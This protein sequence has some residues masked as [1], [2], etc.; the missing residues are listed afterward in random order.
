MTSP[1]LNLRYVRV[2]LARTMRD[3]STIM[4]IFLMPPLLFLVFGSSQQ[5]VQVMHA[6]LRFYVLGGMAA[7][8]ATTG[9]VSIVG[10]AANEAM[11]GWG[12]QIALT[13]APA[14]GMVTNKVAL[15]LIVCS[16][17]IVVT[18][19]VGLATGAHAEIGVWWGTFLGC[20]VGSLMFAVYGLAVGLNFRA[21]SAV[22]AASAGMVFFSFLGNV[23]MPLSGVMLTIAHFTPM[24]GVMALV[25]WPQLRGNVVS[26]DGVQGSDSMWQL[27]LSVVVWLAIFTAF[28]LRGVRVAR[29]RR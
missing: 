15:T 17:S 18:L 11:Q 19:L 25:R 13:K 23:F 3:V 6:N 2:D 21:E 20:L 7:Y 10:Q 1:A 24:Y 22:G 26:T 12:C 28:A 5:M 16:A 9:A 4:F 14:R 27:V 8:G 29:T